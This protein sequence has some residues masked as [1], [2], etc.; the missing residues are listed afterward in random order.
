[1]ENGENIDQENTIKEFIEI[2]KNIKQMRKRREDSLSRMF[3]E[4]GNYNIDLFEDKESKMQKYLA[5]TPTRP[6]AFLATNLG[7]NRSSMETKYT[8][9]LNK[10]KLDRRSTSGSMRNALHYETLKKLI[11]KYFEVK[12]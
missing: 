10:F 1:M 11:I 8:D 4:Y 3:W 7:F 6:K 5:D 12:K 2:L 9:I